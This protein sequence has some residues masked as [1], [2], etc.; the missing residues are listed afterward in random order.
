MSE[1]TI[2]FPDGSTRNYPSGSTGLQIA[3]SISP[4]LAKDALAVKLDDA[5]IDL[6]RPL[7]H[8]GKIQILTWDTPEGKEVFWHSSAHFMAQA[9]LAMADF[10]GSTSALIEYCESSPAQEFIVMTESGINHSLE[11]RAPGKKFYYV[12]NE[13]CN[14]S[15]CP[16]MKRNTLEKLRDSLIT[17]TPRVELS[18]DIIRRALIPIERMLA[19]TAR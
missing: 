18:D 3:Q 12:A 2:T 16:Y 1:I 8:N 13:N 10:I 7:D 4:R 17:L 14:C 19:L 9:V 15:E 5:V 11:R 6:T